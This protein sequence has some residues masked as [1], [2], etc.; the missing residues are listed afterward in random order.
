MVINASRMATIDCRY[1]AQRTCNE[2]LNEYTPEIFSQRF[3]LAVQNIVE[4]DILR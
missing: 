3:K 1:R 2:I 4:E